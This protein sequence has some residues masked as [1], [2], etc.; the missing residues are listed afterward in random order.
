MAFQIPAP[1]Q[2]NCKGDTTVNWKQFKEAY[3]DYVTVLEIGKKDAKI[4]VATLKTL[5][6]QD[7]RKILTG[8]KLSEDKMKDPEEILKALEDKFV[9]KHNCLYD[10]FNF[11]EAFQEPH[12]KVDP[13]LDRLRHLASTCNFGTKEEEMIRDRLVLGSTDN[14]SRARLMRKEEAC[15]LKVAIDELRVSE[16]TNR[17][18]K[19]I[20]GKSDHQVNYAKKKN[21]KPKKP[22]E[23][24]QKSQKFKQKSYKDSPKKEDSS[25]KK[26][27]CMFCG[28]KHQRRKCPAFG[29]KCEKCHRMHHFGSVCFTKKSV[30]QVDEQDDESSSDYEEV[31][32]LDKVEDLY[33]KAVKK[34]TKLLA[35]MIM[36]GSKDIQHEEIFEI[37]TGAN[38]NILPERSLQKIQHKLEK[39]NKLRM[40]DG[41]IM[42]PLGK[43][44]IKVKNPKN[45]KKYK[46]EFV[47]VSD[48]NCQPIIGRDTSFQMG[49]LKIQEENIM[50]VNHTTMPTM[51]NE[52]KSPMVDELEEQFPQVLQGTGVFEGKYHLH[53]DPSVKPV[54]H[55]P[56]R[57]PV[58][59]RERLKTSL[60]DLEKQ[61]IIAKVSEPTP[62]VSSLVLVDR[63]HKL[64][65][66]LDPKD[67]NSA[68]QRSH[69]PMP[70]IEDILPDLHN[71]KIFSLLDARN[72]F[73]HVEL[74]EESSLLTCFNSPYGRY[75]WKRMPFGIS[76]AP[77]EYQRRQDQ[78]LEGLNGVK[79]V[80]D[81]ILVYGKGDTIEEATKDH[82]ENLKCLMQRCQDKGLKINKQ[83]VRLGMSELKF[84]GHTISRDGLKP[85]SEKV[86]AVKEMPTPQ[87][88]NDVRR[89]IGFINY[90]SK[91]LPKLSDM[92]EPL[93]RLTTD[94]VTWCWLTTHDEAMNKIKD[95]V[96]RDPV[97]QYF[98]LTKELVLQADASEKG[99]GAALMQEGHPIAYA[100]RALTDTE[101]R[102]AQIEKELLA[103]LF[104]LER[105]NTYTYG[106]PVLVQSDHKPLE[107]IQKKHLQRAPKRLQRMLLD[108]AVYDYTIVYTPGKQMFLADTL[109]RA[110]LP[111]L[112]GESTTHDRMDIVNM[113]E[114][115]DLDDNTVADIANYYHEGADMQQLQ[116]I[117]LHGW[118][119]EKHQI[120][121]NMVP[122]FHL[123]DELI[124]EN[125]LIYK[126]EQLLIPKAAR[127][128]M[129]ELIHSSHQGM[130][131]NI[132]RAR[133]SVFWPGMTAQLK[134]FIGQCDVCLQYSDKQ[135]KET[136]QS[137][138]VPNRPWAKV[139]MDIFH[140]DNRNYLITVD[141]FSNYWEIDYLPDLKSETVIH[142]AKAHF[143]RHGIP[144]CVVSDN[145]TQFSSEQFQKFS[146]KWGFEHITSSPGYAQSNGKAENA[147]KTAKRLLKKAKAD[148][149]D[150]Y[151][152]ILDF[153]NS[154]SHDGASPV[155]KLMSRRTKT[156]LPTTPKL[157]KP[158]VQP[159]VSKKIKETKE[160]QAEQYN[161][162]AKNL[163]PLKVG[164]HV[165]VFNFQNHQWS[166][167]ATV[168][169]KLPNRSYIV[170]VKNGNKLR[171][172]RRHLKPAHKANVD[173]DM[174]DYDELEPPVRRE[175]PAA[176]SSGK[177]RDARST[178]TQP[179]QH[180][181]NQ[182]KTTSSMA[183]PP[184]TTRTG[185]TVKPPRYLQDYQQT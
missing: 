39:T 109:S 36:G 80:A 141:Y 82:N 42:T 91:F 84:M 61:G 45:D 64:R 89:F 136:L 92:C 179:A 132:K 31:H 180:P 9:V 106:R 172:N 6:G 76:S 152:A 87:N 153:R 161:K 104:G 114:F 21:T 154:P 178:K 164:Q 25:P 29:H 73:W 131:A 167:A 105:F 67:L 183:K 168:I 110:Y 79:S 116:D 30:K 94:D 15:S 103:T 72:G 113:L 120:S 173:S 86:K 158:K 18:L 184:V 135:Q 13:Y 112:P 118:P 134:D 32:T 107:M 8:L 26:E 19:E 56:R 97:L 28:T 50:T 43:S 122:Y 70:T 108:M 20:D 17:Q 23:S 88:K 129:M 41:T 165:K 174:D 117:I 157:L 115:T 166:I 142:K 63:G 75:R 69:Y 130:E 148:N 60:D 146:R 49:L 78:I 123:R 34:D 85:D 176:P 124:T 1:P 40:Y 98:D 37:D 81:D 16:I 125:D 22:K 156:R 93:R 150:P 90:L 102:Y 10:R 137:H 53:L 27:D 162:A 99:L 54:V 169:Q 139:G 128:E 12:E 177:Q 51:T 5:M 121:K 111:E 175:P 2:M 66:C 185:R 151:L 163:A 127:K 71:A 7:C 83:K 160:K 181:T 126:G 100:S 62:W 55:P 14:R 24:E 144:D 38:C 33:C 143:A 170:Q 74:D 68:I 149:K 140:L 57:V 48:P 77:E 52:T 35:T 147:V 11:Y 101:T 44:L 138:E 65:I 46:I 133:E 171:R 159:G 47:V 95:A 59:L 58:A 155:Q 119:D 3:E 182:Q 96:C 4:Q 145:G